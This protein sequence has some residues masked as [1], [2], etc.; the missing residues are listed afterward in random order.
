MNQEPELPPEWKEAAQSFK[1]GTPNPCTSCFIEG[2]EQGALWMWKRGGEDPPWS[3]DKDKLIGCQR[4]AAG[5][6]SEALAEVHANFYLCLRALGTSE[7]SEF[8]RGIIGAAREELSKSQNKFLKTFG[9]MEEPG[10]N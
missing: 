3:L 7:L 6:L 5:E 1:I 10:N 4:L 8:Q 2:F 9:D